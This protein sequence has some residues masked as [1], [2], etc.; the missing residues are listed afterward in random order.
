MSI[1]T[2]SINQNTIN[3]LCGAAVIVQQKGHVYHTREPVPLPRRETDREYDWQNLEWPTIEV[4][5][6]LLGDIYKQVL[7]NTKLDPFVGVTNFDMAESVIS[8][9]VK[10]FRLVP[11]IIEQIHV[12]IPDLIIVPR[13]IRA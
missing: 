8:L 12:N 1:N 11:I 6:E 9:D 4:T 10:D 7:D 5:V 13:K 2:C 3:A